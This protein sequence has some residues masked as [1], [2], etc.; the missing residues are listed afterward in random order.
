[1]KTDFI[2]NIRPLGHIH[3]KRPFDV[4][5][6]SSRQYDLFPQPSWLY[7]DLGQSEQNTCSC[8]MSSLTNIMA[9]KKIKVD[10]EGHTFQKKW[11]NN[12]FL[13]K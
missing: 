1:M 4:A 12:Y 3:P 9:A 6:D 7:T 8:Y 13:L 2:R 10:M 5:H 11:T